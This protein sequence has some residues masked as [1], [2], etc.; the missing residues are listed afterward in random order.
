MRERKL[1]AVHLRPEGASYA[2]E[3]EEFISGQPL[4]VTDVVI[5]PK[6]GAMYVAVGG[7]GAQSALYRVTYAGGDVEPS[8]PQPPDAQASGARPSFLTIELIDPGLT[9]EAME[10]AYDAFEEVFR[11]RGRSCRCERQHGVGADHRIL[12]FRG[13]AGCIDQGSA[14][15]R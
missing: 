1:R 7:R 11:G 10:V 8:N 6:D 13:V 15:R 12:Q 4:P 14:R 3:V 9:R 2:A 5:N